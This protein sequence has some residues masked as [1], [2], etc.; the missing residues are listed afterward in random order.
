MKNSEIIKYI[1]HHNN[2]QGFD[3]P[4]YLGADDKFVVHDKSRM[5]YDE[6]GNFDEEKLLLWKS[7]MITDI[8]SKQYLTDRI[9]PP[10]GDQF[11]YIYHNGVDAWKSWIDE[12]VKD[13]WPKP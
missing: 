1:Q 7:E 12:T 10:I 13:K 4:C 3:C 9:Y 5:P 6:K 8:E 2:K 11:D